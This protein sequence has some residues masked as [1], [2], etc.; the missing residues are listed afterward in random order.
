M[1][2]C[3]ESESESGR[4]SNYGHSSTYYNIGTG[5]GDDLDEELWQACAGPLV[6]VPKAGETVF[7]FPQGH[8]EQVEAY[9]NRDGDVEM[10]IYKLP[11][12]ILCKVVCVQL[13]AEIHTDEV[14]AQITLL[15]EAKQ[16]EVNSNCKSSPTPQRDNS[17]FFVK[18]LT[19]SD[20]STHGGCS[21][22]KR[23]AEECLPYLD[24]SQPHP[25]QDLVTKD[26]HGKEWRF[27]HIYRGK[28]KRH[29]L[30][31]GWSDFLTSKKLV[32][33]D[34]CIFLR[35][36]DGDVRI[37]VR[38]LMKSQTTASSSV[39]SAHSM[40]HGILGSA[41]HAVSTGTMFSV[42]CRPWACTSGFIIAYDQYMKAMANGY[43]IGERFRMKFED[44]GCGEQRLGGTVVGIEDI[45]PLT[46]PG[47][48]WR[49]IKVQWDSARAK[50]IRPERV[51]PWDI[52]P[53]DP[54]R[55]KQAILPTSLKRICPQ[56]LPLHWPPTFIMDGSQW[57]SV[58]QKSRRYSGVFQG[59]E[60]SNLPIYE[61]NVPR[62]LPLVPCL[63]TPIQHVELAPQ[64]DGGKRESLGPSG[65]WPPACI[66][67]GRG[68]G[69]SLSAQDISPA[70]STSQARMT[71]QTKDDNEKTIAKT[72]CFG[73][74]KVFGVNLADDVSELHSPQV[75]NSSELSSPS[76]V[77][78]LSKPCDFVQ[79]II[80]GTAPGRP[81]NLR[82]LKG[83]DDLIHRLNQMCD[84]HGNLI[85]ESSGWHVKCMDDNGDSVPIWD[86]TWQELVPMVHQILI[87]PKEGEKGKPGPCSS[88]VASS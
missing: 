87:C 35:G 63:P 29:L 69:K 19:R 56:N 39:L 80:N 45:D 6:Y 59:Q 15:P 27:R 74:C 38:R 24:K 10:P 60:K 14:F 13:K 1:S 32:D 83:Y 86:Y 76:S 16:D 57:T 37:G 8:I 2:S 47:S 73:K 20:I 17:P 71:S 21:L 77:P 42:Y 49:C 30:T 84:F 51:S 53:L 11:S 33:G 7:Y 72:H 4:S 3:V 68:P 36:R 85:D 50:C 54:D 34:A 22:P 9:T 46:W 65:Q 79:V 81:V 25:V 18:I 31:R 67:P 26:L 44:Y 66:A 61:S 88:D 43:F 12:K 75:A 41:L 28:P 55:K 23:P 64:G 52:E 82:Q 5:R 58:A 62:P 40:R 70:N 78:P 48:D